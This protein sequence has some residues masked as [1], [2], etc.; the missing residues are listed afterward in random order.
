MSVHLP[1]SKEA[2]IE[3]ENRMMATKN[4]LKPTIGEISM[5]P[6]KDIILGCY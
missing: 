2:Q 1:L 4:L 3:C 6:A 5:K